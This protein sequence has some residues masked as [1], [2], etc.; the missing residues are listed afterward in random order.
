VPERGQNIHPL[1][2]EEKAGGLRNDCAFLSMF[3]SGA[4][5][6]LFLNVVRGVLRCQD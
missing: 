1:L 5:W 4:L 2:V 6:T 3:G